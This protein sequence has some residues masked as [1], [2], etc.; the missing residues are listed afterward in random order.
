MNGEV[1]SYD[2]GLEED[3]DDHQEHHAVTRP[4]STG[5]PLD[6]PAA[7]FQAG[8]DRRGANR[9]A[10]IQWVR[11]EL[12]E[13]VD[14]GRIEIRGRLSKP[15]LYKPGAEKICGMLGVIA[16]FP[17]LHDYEERI[18]QGESLDQLL[19]RCELLNN[20]GQVVATGAGSR[21]VTQDGGDLNKALKMCLKSA[22]I[23]AT[24]RLGGLSEVFTQD[25]EDMPREAVAGDD[26]PRQDAEPGTVPFGKHRGQQWAEVPTDYLDWAVAKAS[27]KQLQALAR[28]ELDRRFHCDDDDKHAGHDQDGPPPEAYDDIPY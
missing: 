6:M 9:K 13:N 5:N 4:T 7:Q 17:T 15:S 16:T 24:L 26:R 14:F 25:I 22:M 28:Q 2:P 12:V 20:M 8:L 11:G 18:L 23:D 21:S 10:L 1:I 27:N 19:I 3:Q